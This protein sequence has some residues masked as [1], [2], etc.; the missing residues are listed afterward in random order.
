MFTWNIEFMSFFFF[1]SST[2][3]KCTESNEEKKNERKN[4]EN[5]TVLITFWPFF[6]E[7]SFDAYQE[8]SILDQT[9][10]L[11]AMHVCAKINFRLLEFAVE[12][13]DFAMMYH[14]VKLAKSVCEKM[15][16]THTVDSMWAAKYSVVQSCFVCAATNQLIVEYLTMEIYGPNFSS[17]PLSNVLLMKLNVQRLAIK[18]RPFF[19]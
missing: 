15:S 11:C 9:R 14:S 18:V 13:T 8:N 1:L 16:K 4:E 5:Q 19:D 17:F 7:H 6:L 10:C 12:R 2:V 3:C